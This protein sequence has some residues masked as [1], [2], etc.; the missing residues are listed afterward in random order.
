MSISLVISVTTQMLNFMKI[1]FI[2]IKQTS[3]EILNLYIVI[4]YLLC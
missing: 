2:I 1:L 4:E 3:N